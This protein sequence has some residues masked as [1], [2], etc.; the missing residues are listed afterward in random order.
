LGEKVFFLTKK[1]KGP[2]FQWPRGF[3][4]PPKWGGLDF[5]ENFESCLFFFRFFFF[6]LFFFWKKK[7]KMRKKKKSQGGKKKTPLDQSQ[8]IGFLKKPPY[9]PPFSPPRLKLKP[10]LGKKTI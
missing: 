4:F 5:F 8:K 2:P 7:F 10:V 1:K 6:F 9:P 3:F